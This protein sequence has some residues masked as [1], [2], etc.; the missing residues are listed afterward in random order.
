MIALPD[1]VDA[2]NVQ[3]DLS[4]GVLRLAL[5]K[6]PESKPKKIVLKTS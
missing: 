4:N 5:P 3:A 1:E 6:T 2:G